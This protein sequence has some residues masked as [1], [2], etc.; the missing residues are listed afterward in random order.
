M[1]RSRAARSAAELS[2]LPAA[3]PLGPARTVRDGRLGKGSTPAGYPLYGVLHELQVLRFL[4]A[5]L[6]A[7]HVHLEAL[8]QV[9]SQVLV[10]KVVER[11]IALYARGEVPFR[12]RC[13]P[14]GT[15]EYAVLEAHAADAE[16]HA[17][18]VAS[19]PTG[20]TPSAHAIFTEGSRIARGIVPATAP[21]RADAPRPYPPHEVRPQNG[22]VST[23][24]YVDLTRAEWSALRDR[25]PLPLTAEE[26]EQLRGLG[27]VIDLDEVRDVYLPLSRLLNLY[28]GATAGLRGA[29]QHLPR[30]TPE[31]P[32]RPA[33]HARSS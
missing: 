23:K 14:D 7:Q 25:T 11:Q 18:N 20:R 21:G 32:G 22:P 30:A 13:E 2:A 24:P 1:R 26:V 29:A 8:R 17:G 9:F 6:A 12:R 27:D 5:R 28:V 10:G 19:K 33:R 4:A 31:R 15:S 3:R 16:G